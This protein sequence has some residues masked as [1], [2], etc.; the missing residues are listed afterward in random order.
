MKSY[1]NAMIYHITTKDN[2]VQTIRRGL[3]NTDYGAYSI[4][5]YVLIIL[6]QT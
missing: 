2:S 5:R 4:I 1:G 6:Y 3:A